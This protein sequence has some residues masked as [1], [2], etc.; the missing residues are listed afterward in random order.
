M[1]FDYEETLVENNM[2]K[3]LFE[4][5]FVDDDHKKTYTLQEASDFFWARNLIDKG[6]LAEQAISKIIK[7][8]QNAP[9]TMGS[10][11]I[12]G[13]ESKYSEVYYDKRT[14]YATIGN[15]KN[16]TGAIRAWVY[17]QKYTKENYYFII[18]HSVYAPYFQDGKKSTMKIWFDKNGNPRRPTNNINADLWDCQVTEKEFREFKQ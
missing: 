11:F 2:N 12:D 1:L 5:A 6:E 8:Q 18:P 10:D 15:I 14:T 4:H 13:S 17:E 7:V 16:K 9:N 3:K